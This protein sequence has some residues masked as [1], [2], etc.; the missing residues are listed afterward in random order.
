MK[1]PLA[2]AASLV[3]TFGILGALDWGLIEAQRPPRG[4]VTVTQLPY[5]SNSAL[6]AQVNLDGQV[7]VAGNL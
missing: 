2:L 3:I 7:V 4:E 6:L 1:I 5:P